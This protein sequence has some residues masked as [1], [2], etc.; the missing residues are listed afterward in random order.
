MYKRQELI[1]HRICDPE[2]SW[3]LMA[4]ALASPARV[5]I[6]Q[7]QDVLALGSEA[8]MNNPARVTGNWRWMMTP[9]ALTAAHA[10][11]LRELTEGS[12]RIG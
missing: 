1:S 12:G 11:R 10:A 9:G 4:L 2:P 7:A 3:R 5:T 6:L 8:R